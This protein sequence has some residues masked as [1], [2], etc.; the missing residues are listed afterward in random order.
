MS[1]LFGLKFYD[2]QLDS[3]VKELKNEIKRN[4]KVS[5]FTPNIDHVINNYDNEIVKKIYSESEYIIADGWPIV[6][7]GKLKKINIKR[8]T[9][10]DLMDELLRV[11]NEEKYNIFF[12]G[13]T[14]DTLIKLKRNIITKYPNINNV[15][16]NHGFFDND[17]EVI[18]KINS[19]KSNILFVGMGN[20]KQE[21]WIRDNMGS[22][23][24]NLMVG[25]GGAFKIFSEEVKRAPK[26]VQVIGMEWFYRFSKEPKR[27]FYR[28]FIKYPKFIKILFYEFIDK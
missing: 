3:L 24:C 28:Y 1:N 10:V 26:W 5:I 18:K 22:L 6:A 11:A 4:N 20:P 25:V 23:D 16:Y 14:E 27:L 15:W 7:S 9:G 19:S 17:Y 12:L 8:I 2:K 13:A 21:T